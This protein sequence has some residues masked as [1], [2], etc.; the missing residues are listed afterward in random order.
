MPRYKK[1]VV[2]AKRQIRLN[3]PI[4]QKTPPAARGRSVSGKPAGRGARRSRAQSPHT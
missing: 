3:D 4:G 2:L 1:K